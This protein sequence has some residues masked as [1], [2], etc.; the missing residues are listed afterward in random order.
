MGLEAARGLLARGFGSPCGAINPYL[1]DTQLDRE[2]GRMLKSTM[3]DLGVN[4]HLERW[5]VN[6]LGDQRV[7][8]LAFREGDLLDWR[9]GGGGGRAAQRGIIVKD[10]LSCRNNSDVYSIGE[11]AQHRGQIYGVVARL[12]DQA[13]IFAQRLTE[14]NPDALSRARRSPPS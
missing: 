4:I 11:R 9:H 12:W 8:G 7:S 13:G 1:M 2:S 6:V 10:H 5:T 14:E 3:E